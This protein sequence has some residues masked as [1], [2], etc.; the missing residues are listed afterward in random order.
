MDFR[1]GGPLDPFGAQFD[2]KF[3]RYLFSGVICCLK[4]IRYLV[5][6]PFW[7]PFL[8]QFDLKLIRYI[9]SGAI[10]SLKLVRYLFVRPFWVATLAQ[11]SFGIFLGVC[12]LVTKG[13]QGVRKELTEATTGS[14]ETPR[15]PKESTRDPKRAP[16]RD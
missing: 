16:K 1:G 2:L 9:V 11:N 3:I 4:L 6:W 5:V 15:E 10:C 12:N 14:Q 7:M 8:A 13:P